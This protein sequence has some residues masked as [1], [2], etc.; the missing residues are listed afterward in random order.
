MAVALRCFAIAALGMLWLPASALA[1]AD[2]T[3]HATTGILTV[4]D[5]V[6][7]TDGITISQTA[8]NHVVTMNT[9]GQSLSSSD[10]SCAPLGSS[11]IACSRATSIAVDMKD[12]DDSVSAPSVTVPISIAGGD[13]NDT[14]NGGSGPD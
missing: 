2:V 5:D 7:A 6:N 4:T 14:L 8:T 9:A 10:G 11:Q 1:D 3:R 12:L 13:G